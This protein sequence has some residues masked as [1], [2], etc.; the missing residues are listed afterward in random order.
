ML[1]SNSSNDP[2]ML[3]GLRGL[4]RQIETGWNE[5]IFARRQSVVPGIEAA[6]DQHDRW[7][8]RYDFVRMAVEHKTLDD[9][10]LHGGGKIA[11]GKGRVGRCLHPRPHS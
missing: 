9:E 8:R 1:E 10:K 3:A 5:T 7:V 4:L 11:D 6:C 2:V